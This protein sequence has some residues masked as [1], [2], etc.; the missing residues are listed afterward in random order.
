MIVTDLRSPAVG[1]R[2]GQCGPVLVSVFDGWPN[3]QSLAALAE[4]QRT[5]ATSY[6]RIYSMTIIPATPSQVAKL[7]QPQGDRDQTLK[8]S[9]EV[10]AR[11]QEILAAN[12]MVILSRGVVAVLVR[13]FMAALSLAS[14]SGAEVKTF[15]TLEEAEAWFRTISG[16][17]LIPERLAE[18]ITEWLAAGGAP[19]EA[20]S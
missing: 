4:A 14:T 1:L 8:Q 9:A 17:P 7:S 3:G 11:M 15:K 20:A 12:A 18:G 5:L 19:K 2:L 6:P 10:A 16:A 13:T